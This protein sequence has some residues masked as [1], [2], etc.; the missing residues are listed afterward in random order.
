MSFERATLDRKSSL[1]CE[2]RLSSRVSALSAM[3]RVSRCDVDRKPA[4]TG[5][6]ANETTVLPEP[7][8]ELG[9]YGLDR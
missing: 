6:V 1:K 9:G 7:A 8:A 3:S 4:E 2:P 5:R